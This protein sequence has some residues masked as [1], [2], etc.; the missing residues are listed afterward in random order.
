MQ[1]LW[2]KGVIIFLAVSNA[3]SAAPQAATPEPAN[4]A[5]PATCTTAREYITTLEYLRDRKEFAVP[6]PEA[7]KVA[8]DASKGCTGAAQRFIRISLI[9]SKAGVSGRDAIRK[10]LEFAN[11]TDEEAETFAQVFR[12]AYSE[13]AMDLD[14]RNSLIMA[15]D[16]TREFGANTVAVR[17]D[18]EKLLDFCSSS[19][20]LGLPKPQCGAFAARLAKQGEKWNGGISSPY[21]QA[22][23][24]VTS[25]SGPNL[26]T[27]KA[28]EIADTLAAAGPGSTENFITAYKYAVSK[29]GLGLADGAAVAF[30][31]QI[32]VKSGNSQASSK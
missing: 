5:P 29:K 32:G 11:R 12:T 14:L 4:P 3:A 17:K 13:D 22:F 1:K 20:R 9:L 8:L 25:K 2:V 23:D 28:I 19:G 18:F 16:L 27:S 31:V 15:E 10:G 26:A 21:I 24:F 7:Q 30:A 6:E